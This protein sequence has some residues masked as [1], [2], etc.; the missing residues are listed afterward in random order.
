LTEQERPTGRVWAY[1]ER[2][3]G[4]ISAST[5]HG[6]EQIRGRHGIYADEGEDGNKSGE[7]SRGGGSTGAEGIEGDGV[8]TFDRRELGHWLYMMQ[9]NVEAMPQQEHW[10]QASTGGE[11]WAST[12][13]VDDDDDDDDDDD[14]TTQAK[15][16][17][18]CRAVREAM[19]RADALLQRVDTGGPAAARHIERAL[20]RQFD[21]EATSAS[22]RASGGHEGCEPPPL[23]LMTREA[24]TEQRRQAELARY[25]RELRRTQQQQEKLMARKTRS[26]ESELSELKAL[27][28]QLLAKKKPP[29]ACQCPV[30]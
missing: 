17:A 18:K 12:P 28:Q 25:Q 24:V 3:S 11:G 5:G 15:E 30:C 2:A 22:G 8:L 19:D 4:R 7:V 13:P 23:R 21:D 9:N 14:H 27:A 1:G 16:E 10:A 6:V 29:G 26:Q 20:Q